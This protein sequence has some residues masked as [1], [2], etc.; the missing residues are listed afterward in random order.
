MLLDH[1]ETCGSL[2]LKLRGRI[3]PNLQL[4]IVH[5]DSAGDLDVFALNVGT[6]KLASTGDL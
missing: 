2:N 3:D 5:L 6:L 1:A 4:A